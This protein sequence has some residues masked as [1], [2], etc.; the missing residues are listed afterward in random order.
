MTRPNVHELEQ[1]I[2]RQKNRIKNLEEKLFELDGSLMKQELQ[3]A[4]R[5]EIKE[6][7]YSE[8]SLLA[9]ASKDLFG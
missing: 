1:V 8:V 2:E 7:N 4:I 3:E 6:R 5:K 9:T